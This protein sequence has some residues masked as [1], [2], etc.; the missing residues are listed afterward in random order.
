M[1]RRNLIVTFV[2]GFLALGGWAWAQ[3]KNP[4]LPGMPTPQ[5]EG[6]PYAVASVGQSAILLDTKTGKTWELTH[7]ADGQAVWLPGK[8]IDSDKEAEEWRHRD[9]NFRQQ[10]EEKKDRIKAGKEEM[11]K[12]DKDVAEPIPVRPRGK[13]LD[14]APANEKEKRPSQ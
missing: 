7:S 6:G 12:L 10:L 2:V 3:Q 11:K 1:T 13:E 8:R 4:G 14:I 5:Q 9:K